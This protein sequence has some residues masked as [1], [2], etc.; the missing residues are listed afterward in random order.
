MRVAN[1]I[2][3]DLTINTKLATK[4]KNSWYDA[5]VFSPLQ[6]TWNHSC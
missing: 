5:M 6:L 1:I 3:K 2:E 4:R